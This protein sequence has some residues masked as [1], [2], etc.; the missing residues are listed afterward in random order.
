MYVDVQSAR[1]MM[2][3]AAHAVDSGDHRANVKALAAKTHAVDVAI[4]VAENAVKILGG[5]GVTKEYKTAG[6]LC[7][8]W[9]GWSC[10]GTRGDM[11]RLAMMNFLEPP[12][13]F[14]AP[15]GDL[16]GMEGPHFGG[17]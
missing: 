11:L 4:R 16:P 14:G 17:A 15:G 1:L 3:D 10:D 9:M 12:P 8:A 7:G 13:G 2:W 5:Y 6:Y